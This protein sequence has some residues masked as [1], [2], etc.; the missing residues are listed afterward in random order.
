MK[1]KFYFIRDLLNV[2]I[3]LIDLFCGAGGTTSGFESAEV[4]GSKIAKVIVCVNHD[5]NAI[6]SHSQNHPDTVHMTEDIRTQSME[7][8]LQI[9][10]KWKTLCPNAKVVLWGS[11]ECTNHSNAKGGDSRDADSRSLAEHLDRYIIA[12]QP[13]YVWIENVREFRQ[14]G[15]LLH[16]RHKKTR[17]LMFHKEKATGEMVPTMIPDKKHLRIFF[18]KWISETKKLGY[19]YADKDFNAANFNAHQNR[20]RYFGSFAKKGLPHIFPT[21]FTKQGRAVKE[22]LDFGD[23]GQGIFDSKRKKKITSPKTFDRLAAGIIKHVIPGK[24]S[25]L[26]KYTNHGNGNPNAGV[27]V[28]KSCP[29][30]CAEQRLGI[31][32]MKYAKGNEQPGDRIT[33]L[34]KYFSGKA[35]NSLSIE[36]P[37]GSITAIDHHAI[38]NCDF[39]TLYYT[40]GGNT[41]SVENTCPAL[42][43]KDRVQKCKVFFIDNQ[44]G[45]SKP[46]SIESPS[47]SILRNP[48]QSLVGAEWIDNRYGSGSHNHQSVNNPCGSVLQIPKQALMTAKFLMNHNFGNTP[49]SINAPAPSLLASRKHYY[50]VSPQYNNPP[51]SVNKVCPTVIAIQDKKPL[52]LA[53]LNTISAWRVIIRETNNPSARPV[54]ILPMGTVVYNLPSKKLLTTG[55]KKTKDYFLAKRRLLELMAEYGIIDIKMRMLKI[56]ELLKIQGFPENYKLIGTQSEQKKYI[57]NA[58]YTGIPKRWAEEFHMKHNQAA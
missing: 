13:D 56:I 36:K 37:T 51:T 4:N 21:P 35:H 55:T 30:I 26:V 45:Q 33:F 38:V 48:K 17:K 18:D 20:I 2:S 40:A 32:K 6:R 57:G 41:G 25:F 7:P 3:L 11:L 22:V 14:W 8:I 1:R 19:T 43:T 52:S 31:A 42:T 24:E 46:S 58:V 5:K 49:T 27:D 9:L 39:L 29:T 34:S 44:Y 15:P 23:E 16:K 54:H 47:G 50:I 10:N 12:I 53:T 28:D